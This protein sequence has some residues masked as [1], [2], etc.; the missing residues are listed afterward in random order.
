MS[1]VVT[2]GKR[3]RE[4]RVDDAPHAKKARLENDLDDASAGLRQDEEFWE[5][6][7]TIVLVARDVKFRVYKGVLAHHSSVF[8]DMFS[9]PQPTDKT[10]VV[11]LDTPSSCPV[12]HLDDSPEDMRHI[13]RAILPRKE[14]RLVHSEA[15]PQPTPTFNMISAYARLGHKYDIDH[16]L[17]QAVEFLERYFSN[18]FDKCKF[19]PSWSAG[20]ATG[21]VN[22][23][24]LINCQSILLPALIACCAIK[25]KVLLYGIKREDGSREW[26]DDDDFVRCLSVKGLLM[27]QAARA[28]VHSYSILDL[29]ECRRECKSACWSLKFEIVDSIVKND[30]NFTPFYPLSTRAIAWNKPDSRLCQPCRERHSQSIHT[31]QLRIWNSLPEMLKVQVE[32]WGDGEQPQQSV[33]SVWCDAMPSSVLTFV[34]DPCPSDHFLIQK[35]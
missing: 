16:L 21:V 17:R 12:V 15:A 10:A 7:G 8:A 25:A 29:P 31:E 33:D 23:A 34:R 13:L 30:K 6:D 22:I 35:T 27:K 9:L 26:L 3:G 14:A 28:V 24:R 32:G 18:D 4:D 2:A 11:I 20:H 5:D 1:A 19:P